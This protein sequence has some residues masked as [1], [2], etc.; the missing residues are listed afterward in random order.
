MAK[1]GEWSVEVWWNHVGWLGNCCVKKSCGVK[2]LACKG[3]N[4]R[5]QS[6]P[7]TT[8]A[9]SIGSRKNGMVNA[10]VCVKTNTLGQN[11]EH[12]MCFPFSTVMEKGVMGMMQSLR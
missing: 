9:P 11:E 4:E 2:K 7:K 12:W 10:W 1:M 6:I 3:L 5:N 8:L